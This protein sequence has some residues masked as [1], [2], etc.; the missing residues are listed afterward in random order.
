MKTYSRLQE[1]SLLYICGDTSTKYD[2][3][4]VDGINIFLMAEYPQNLDD[5]KIIARGIDYEDCFV[6]YSIS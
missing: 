6:L 1:G 4:T 2:N 3:I 5:I